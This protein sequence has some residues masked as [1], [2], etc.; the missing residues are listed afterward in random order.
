[1][2]GNA[3]IA[4]DSAGSPFDIA[5]HCWSIEP[6]LAPAIVQ[7]FP[8]CITLQNGCAGIAG[9]RFDRRENDAG[10]DRDRGDA[11]QQAADKDAKHGTTGC[12]LEQFI[13]R[14]VLPDGGAYRQ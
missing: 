10:N 13:C 9:Q 11:Q 8:G 7:T 14:Q 3:E 12:R 4:T 5:R 6:E 1:M 2:R